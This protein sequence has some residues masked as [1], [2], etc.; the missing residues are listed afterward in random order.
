MLSNERRF[1]HQRIYM[2]LSYYL[3]KNETANKY[4]GRDS[5]SHAHDHDPH[6]KPGCRQFRLEETSSRLQESIW[7]RFGAFSSRFGRIWWFPRSRRRVSRKA[8]GGKAGVGKVSAT[9]GGA[10]TRPGGAERTGDV[11]PQV[12]RVNGQKLRVAGPEKNGMSMYLRYVL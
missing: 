3:S 9:S 5:Q 2:H 10:P 11:C 8:K 7:A 6:S 12:L 1:D 4:S